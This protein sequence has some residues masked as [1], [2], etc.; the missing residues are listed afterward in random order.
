MAKNASVNRDLTEKLK[1]GFQKV[2]KKLIEKEK[3]ENGYLIIGTKDGQVKKVPA[4][5]L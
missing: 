1:E 5:D 3:K 2:R 4:K